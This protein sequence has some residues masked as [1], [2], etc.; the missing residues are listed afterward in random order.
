MPA[1]ETLQPKPCSGSPR[2]RINQQAP[3]ILGDWSTIDCARNWMRQAILPVAAMSCSGSPCQLDFQPRGDLLLVRFDKATLVLWSWRD[4][5]RLPWAEK[6]VGVGSAQFSPDGASIA[7]GFLSGEVQIRTV[8][9]GELIAK[10]RH[11]GQI[12]ALAFSPDGRFL[13]I[14]SETTRV[15]DINAQAFLKPVWPHPR[16]VSALAFNRK[17]DRLITVCEDELVRVFAVEN[18]QD[19]IAPLYAPVRHAAAIAPALVDLDRILV[20]VSGGSELT[21]WDMATGT[22]AS[23]PIRTKAWNLQGVAASRDGNWFATGGYYGPELY[24]ADARQP[25]VQLSHTNLVTRFVFSPDSTM[26]LSVSWDSTAR[27]WSLPHGRPLGP[28]IWHM[29]NVRGMCLVS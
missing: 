10:I 11:Q 5:K 12:T 28:P 17:G 26:L 14:A 13:A 23:T 20:T 19:R 18:R 15:W 7:L 3:T 25:P 1:N 2:L 4:G 21:R 16:Q 24:A 6:M 22:P 27:L 8:T 9:D 29:A